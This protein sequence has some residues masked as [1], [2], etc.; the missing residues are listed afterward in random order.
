MEAFVLSASFVHLTQNHE[1]RRKKERSANTQQPTA[2]FD[3]NNNH[4]KNTATGRP[5]SGAGEPVRGARQ[6]LRQGLPQAHK[7]ER[8]GVRVLLVVKRSPVAP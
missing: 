2:T 3:N 4:T 6:G 1:E 7:Q 8:Q 5:P